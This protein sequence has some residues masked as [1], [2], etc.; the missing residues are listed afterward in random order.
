MQTL[1]Q[2]VIVIAGASSGI[3]RATALEFARQGTRVVI[4]ARR[5]AVL[6]GVAQECSVLGGTALAVP[7][8][9]TDAAAVEALADAALKAFGRIDV[10]VNNVGT[11]V[12]G[13]YQDAPADLHRRV[14]ETNL[15]G[16]MNGVSAALP[17]FLRQGEGILINMVSLGGWA[18]TPFAAAYTASKFGLRGLASALR[19]ELSDRPRIRVCSVFPSLV[20]TPG[21]SH[22][23]N[24]SGRAMMPSGPF[25]APERVAQELVRLA[26]HPRDEVAIGLPAY[27]AWLG[28]MLAPKLTERLLGAVFRHYMRH[29]PA[30]PRTEGAVLVPMPEGTGSRGGWRKRQ[31]ML[32]A[33]STPGIALVGL[34]VVLGIALTARHR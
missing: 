24:V 7:T 17:T 4:A 20:D 29:A 16:A 14:V 32:M 27:A 18:P 21:L 28:Y 26:L 34:A 22:G 10:W 2:A 25:L 9:V 19:S 15:I 23:A 11:G 6:D 8:D 33:T 30:S 12:F 1:R 13:A 31:P 5:A 3:G